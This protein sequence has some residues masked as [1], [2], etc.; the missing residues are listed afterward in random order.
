MN[1]TMVIARRELT[2]KRFVFI[3]AAAFLLLTLIVPFMP[4]V[5]AGDRQDAVVIASLILSAAFTIGLAAI[6]G[7]SMIGRELSDGRLSFY[8]SKP[9]PAS[10][11][12]FGKLI[13]AAALIVVSFGIVAL[14][15]VFAG[16]D[17]VLRT[18]TSAPESIVRAI[19]AWAA[20]LFLLAHVIGT[21]VRSRS[22]WIVFD[23]IAAAV[24]GI[25]IWLLVRPLLLGSAVQL[26]LHLGLILSVYAAVAIIGAGAWQVGRGRTDRK[27]SHM[28]L[29]RFLWMSL[30]CGLLLVAAFVMW[31]VSVPIAEITPEFVEQADN[32]SWAMIEGQAKHRNDYHAAFLYN[33]SDGRSVR[34]P[35]LK[36]WWG[37]AFSADGNTAAWYVRAPGAP[38]LYIARLNAPKP[39]VIATASKRNEGV[40]IF[41]YDVQK[42]ALQKT[43]ALPKMLRFNRDRSLGLLHTKD[44]YEIRNARTGA[45]Q[46]S[47]PARFAAAR[48]LRD[49]RIVALE[50]S[51]GSSVLRLLNGDGT[52]VRTV[53]LPGR[54]ANFMTEASAGLVV[55]PIRIPQ[56]VRLASAVVDLDRGVVV[57]IDRQ[58]LPTVR[59]SGPRLL[60]ASP[61]GFVVW[62]PATGEKRRVGS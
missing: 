36:P 29:S 6:L 16:H 1:S 42:R 37:T 4:G 57:R 52:P 18:W 50:E 13:A 26:S 8:F 28:E 38:E 39:Q 40:S 5:R 34:I 7:S 55:V 54:P 14:P 21:F 11:I 10:S 25:A 12:W 35:A 53:A 9:L 22:A 41:E 56:Q 59:S 48:F 49:G 2:E 19:L 33:I 43:G 32:G 30:G 24:C 45:V 17:V 31:V 20:A 23:F 46:R 44:G 58:L 62:N 27:R 3:A 61:N 47:I 60:C 51:N 15:A